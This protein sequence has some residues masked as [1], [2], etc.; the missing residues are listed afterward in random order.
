[1][2]NKTNMILNVKHKLST[3][4]SDADKNMQNVNKKPNIR[5]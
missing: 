1:M 3:H 2:H 4:K 5:S